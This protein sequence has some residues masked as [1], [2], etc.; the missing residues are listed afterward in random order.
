MID[1][2]WVDHWLNV[3]GARVTKTS[4]WA[5]F[6][7]SEEFY[8]KLET[9]EDEDLK[10]AA[11][12]IGRH[13]ELDTLP[14]MTYQW[15][16]TMDPNA[17]GQIRQQGG[18]NSHIEIPL[19]Y[20]GKPFALGAIITHELTHYFL[21]TERLVLPEKVENEQLTDLASMALGLGKLVLNGT[22]ADHL[23]TVREYSF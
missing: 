12:E 10:I 7:P 4:R 6:E 15:G 13:L 14:S 17:A 20:V 22:V 5:L 21:N 9:G 3:L 1:K 18:Q 16:I 19:F 23:Q 2:T 8:E 11:A